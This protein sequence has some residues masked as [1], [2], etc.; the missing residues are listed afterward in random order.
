MSEIAE[1]YRTMFRNA[2]IQ[3]AI[4]EATQPHYSRIMGLFINGEHTP[5]TRDD[6]ARDFGE[7]AAT[8]WEGIRAAIAEF[9]DATE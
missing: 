8:K 3:I 4:R 9:L 7:A 1:P 6:V 2:K 5:M